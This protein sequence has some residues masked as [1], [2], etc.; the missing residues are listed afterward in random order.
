MIISEVYLALDEV[1]PM[2]KPTNLARG[3]RVEVPQLLRVQEGAVALRLGGQLVDVVGPGEYAGK[4]LFP[5][6]ELLV[7]ALS[8]SDVVAWDDLGKSYW[9]LVELRGQLLQ[10]KLAECLSRL[11]ASREITTVRILRAL[12]SLRRF[13]VESPG[14]TT[15]PSW[16][17]HELLAEVVGS[18]R[19]VATNAI[20]AFHS[21]GAT[22]RGKGLV[23]LDWRVLEDAS[24]SRSTNYR[25]A[26]AKNLSNWRGTGKVLAPELGSIGF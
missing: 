12:E 5:D 18:T 25:S 13:A 15:Y 16:V 7:T 14:A 8:E 22:V 10:H 2:R 4:F 23:V 1:L 11:S 26:V 24:S 9:R 19:E 21:A 17:T 6:E 3:R 20:G